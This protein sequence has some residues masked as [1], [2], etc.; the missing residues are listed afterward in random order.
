MC[1]T[2]SVNLYFAAA[3]AVLVMQVVDSSKVC[4]GNND[5][6]FATLMPKFTNHQTEGIKNNSC[7][8]WNLI[9][10]YICVTICLDPSVAFVESSCL[11]KPTIRHSL[12]Y[13]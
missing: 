4:T 11:G 6:Q 5:V 3:D 7:I 10:H 9:M 12:V 8:H 13:T 2:S 1:L